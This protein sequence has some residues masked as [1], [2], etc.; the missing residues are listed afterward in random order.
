MHRTLPIVRPVVLLLALPL[1]MLGSTVVH[2][3]PVVQA[4]ALHLAD[5]HG[6]DAYAQE[7]RWD[8]EAAP[9][10]AGRRAPRAADTAASTAGT[11][12]SQL[13]EAGGPRAEAVRVD[14]LLRVVLPAVAAALLLVIAFTA[15]AMLRR[16]PD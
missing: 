6:A 16:G 2:E 14:G 7:R 10:R 11:A 9:R 13:A 5:G 15:R 4:T 12:A 8:E 1:L 3:G